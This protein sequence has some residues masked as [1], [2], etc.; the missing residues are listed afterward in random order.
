MSSEFE[1]LRESCLKK[2]ELWQD[3]DFPAVQSSIFYH[4]KPPFNFTWKRPKDLVIEPAFISESQSFDVVQG[5][6]GDR[7]LVQ[8]LGCLYSSKGLF[9]RVVPADQGFHSAD[10]Y[11]GIFRFRIW[12]CGSW[13]EVLVDDRLPTVNNRQVFVSSSRSAE[14]WPALLEKAY[15]KLHGSYEALKYGSVLDGLADLTG[16]V[17]ESIPLKGDPTGSG[18]LLVE[19]LD[20]TSVITANI[21]VE[22]ETNKNSSKVEEKMANGITIGTNY[23]VYDVQKVQTM[24]GELVQLV[25]LRAGD[26]CAYLGSW[27]PGSPD[28][29]Q[30]EDGER[31]RVG[32]RRSPSPGMVGEFWMTY[33]DFIRTFSHLEVVHLDA[34]TARDE[35][36][37]QGKERWSMRLYSGAWQRG[38]TA[39]GCRNNSDTFHINPQLQLH[40][41]QQ[42]KVIL[43]LSQHCVSEPQVIGFTGYPL[44]PESDSIGRS[45]FRSNRSLL[46]SQYTNSRH[47]T[48]RSSLEPGAYM[49]L[50]TT[51]EPGQEATFTFRVLTH[52]Q[53]KLKCVDTSPAII[54]S[55]IVKAPP[56]LTDTKGFEQYDTL[57]MQLSDDR[58]TVNA[59]ELQE[60]L[61]TC[62]P[63]DYIKSCASIEVCRQVVVAMDKERSSLGRLGYSEFKDLIVSLKMWQGVF[64]THTK[65][66]TGVLRAERLRDALLEV[67]FR[68]SSEI[69]SIIVLRYMRKDGTLRFGDFV[70][71]ILNLTVAF[72]L[73]DRKDPNKNGVVKINISEWVRCALS[74]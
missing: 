41:S 6:L 20:M 34:E 25:H 17:A 57:F 59:F 14:F 5:K 51:F 72:A 9:Y 63:N 49:I 13:R 19:L 11:A 16:G 43:S 37:M 67:G 33:T 35:P 53:A 50:P 1:R 8:C 3:P 28:W 7:W 69:L 4:Q 31:E 47:V 38:V 29:D 48:H 73:Y 46:N 24:S 61:E 60:L 2:G 10:D 55:A 70:A 71:I 36:S 40:V 44:P 23:R 26:S 42:D 58:R 39:G 66:K 54:K 45:Y 64:R 21:Q 68:L 62:L 32:A 12:W 18:R 30:V 56:S 15:A 74:C 65:E 27:A 52:G 22:K